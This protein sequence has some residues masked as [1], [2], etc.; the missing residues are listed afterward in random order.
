MLSSWC[1]SNLRTVETPEWEMRLRTYRWHVRGTARCL[2]MPRLCHHGRILIIHNQDIL[3][4]Q[5]SEKHQR[6]DRGWW[7]MALE[8]RSHSRTK[9]VRKSSII[10]Y[11]GKSILIQLPRD[12]GLASFIHQIVSVGQPLKLLAGLY[13]FVRLWSPSSGHVEVSGFSWCPK[14]SIHPNWNTLADDII[15]S[16]TLRH[17]RILDANPHDSWDLE[18]SKPHGQ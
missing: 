16:C 6:P 10:W 2:G 14:I 15:R 5:I 13:Q 18:T 17:R 7:P 4:M 3:R 12:H 11:V 1:L 8:Y 9:C